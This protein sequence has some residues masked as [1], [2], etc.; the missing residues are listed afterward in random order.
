MRRKK[1]KKADEETY[2]YLQALKNKKVSLLMLDAKWHELFPADRKTDE[3]KN[4]ERKLNELL[5]K[6]GKNTNDIKEYEKAKKAIM[7]NIVN[8]MTDGS[9]PDSFLKARKQ[10]K[11]QKLMA[12]LNYK[13]SMAEEVQKELPVQ[14]E[15]AN[16]ELLIEGMKLCYAELTSN[17]EQIEALEEWIKEARDILKNKILEKQDMEMRNTEL[18][19]YMHNLLGAQVVEIFDKNHKIWKG[20]IEENKKGNIQ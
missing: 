4:C 9:G 10:E 12:D 17:T 6:Q 1:N 3:I 11:N 2:M 5:K 16:N 15:V 7:S 13:L 18:Y 8:N 20:N 19:T 14:I